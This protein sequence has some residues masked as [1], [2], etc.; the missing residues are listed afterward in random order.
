MIKITRGCKPMFIHE[1]QT[2]ID[3]THIACNTGR[4]DKAYELP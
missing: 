4:S 3:G 1:Q 2:V